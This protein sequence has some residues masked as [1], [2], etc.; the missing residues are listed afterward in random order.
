MTFKEHQGYLKVSHPFIS[1]QAPPAT[2]GF[3]LH[4]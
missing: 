1:H 4:I 3:G 2:E